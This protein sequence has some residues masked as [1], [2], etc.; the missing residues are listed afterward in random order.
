MRREQAGSMADVL[1]CSDCQ[2]ANAKRAADIQAR[3]TIDPGQEYG[4]HIALTC[5]DHPDLRW[6]TKN[7]DFIGARSLFFA[8]WD[9]GQNECPCPMSKL[10]V[11]S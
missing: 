5:E 8:G 2:E 10:R 7:I 6:T 1:A 9:Q 11:V 3:H 4:A